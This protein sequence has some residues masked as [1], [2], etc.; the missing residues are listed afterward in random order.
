MRIS[1]MLMPSSLTLLLTDSRIADMMSLRSSDTACWI[2]REPNSSRSPRL[3]MLARRSIATSRSEEHTSE[4]QSLMRISYAVFCLQKKNTQGARWHAYKIGQAHL[5]T[6][7]T[8]A[9]H[10]HPPP[11]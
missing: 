8:H 9:T 2:V 10:I 4:L 11:T 3:T 7:S 1:T 6:P 5:Y